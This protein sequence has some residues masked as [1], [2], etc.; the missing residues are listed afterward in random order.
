MFKVKIS[1]LRIK[2]FL[3]LGR[4]KKIQKSNYR[5]KATDL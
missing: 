1:Q 2:A 3:S 5:A 4:E